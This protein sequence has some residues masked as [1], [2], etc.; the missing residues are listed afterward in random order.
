MPGTD[1]PSLIPLRAAPGAPDAA[2]QELV[3]LALTL[4]T[5]FP[6]D[7]DPDERTASASA[8]AGA[9]RDLAARPELTAELRRLC[10][11]LREIWAALEV[12]Q[13]AP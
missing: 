9:L 3:A 6:L 2:S 5:K 13:D 1:E 7:D 11:R 8:I 4:M 12:R 10:V